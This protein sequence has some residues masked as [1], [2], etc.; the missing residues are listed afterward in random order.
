M[1][2]PPMR[3]LL[4][5]V[6]AGLVLLAAGLAVGARFLPEGHARTPPS[7]ERFA[8]R[9]AELLRRNGVEP[10]SGAP[11][12]R[13]ATPGDEGALAYRRLGE[14][15]HDWLVREARGVQVEVTQRGAVGGR[16]GPPAAHLHR[17]GSAVGG[18]VDADATRRLLRHSRAAARA[19]LRAAAAPR[20]DVRRGAALVRRTGRLGERGAHRRLRHPAAPLPDGPRGEH[21]PLLSPAG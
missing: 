15:A 18:R 7:P 11:R 3:S 6:V 19:D 20:R 14:G 16:R 12:V 13:L 9:Y 5:P 2:P 17:R 8:R 4:L 1:T 21:H 10:I